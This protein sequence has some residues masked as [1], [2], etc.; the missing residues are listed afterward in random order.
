LLFSIVVAVLAFAGSPGDS[1]AMLAAD[2][3][4]LPMIDSPAADFYGMHGTFSPTMSENFGTIAVSP[5]TERQFSQFPVLDRHGQRAPAFMPSAPQSPLMNYEQA[6]TPA[7]HEV[8]KANW[9]LV[10]TS[11]RPVLR[12]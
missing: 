10:A 6:P 1:H 5:M 8:M 11:S 12:L 2:S 7:M 9:A 4:F 3:G